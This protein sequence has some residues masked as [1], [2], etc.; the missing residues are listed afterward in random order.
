MSNS[1]PVEPCHAVGGTSVP[2]LVLA[3][4]PRE[5]ANA[6]ASPRVLLALL[7]VL[8][9]PMLALATAPQWWTDL[10]VLDSSA[11]TNDYAAINQGQLKNLA[12][13]AYYHL[14]TNVPPTVWSSQ[15]ATL[16]ALITGFQTS[17]NTARNDYAAV[18]IGQLKTVAKPFY[19]L[20]NKAGY[21]NSVHTSTNGYPWTGREVQANDY[22]MAN[23][24]QAKNLF[25]F[26]LAGFHRELPDSVKQQ[27][28]NADTHDL[29]TS[30]NQVLED[31]DFDG[32]GIS[33]IDEYIQISDP[34]VYTYPTEGAPI[35][36]IEGGDAQT[37]EINSF[38]P[39]PISVR[40]VGGNGQ[41][42]PS[43]PLQF[44]V[45]ASDGR[46]SRVNGIG[47]TTSTSLSIRTSIDGLASVWAMMPSTSGDMTI[48]ASA[49]G[50]SGA[51]VT[52]TLHANSGVVATPV[53]ASSTAYAT[54][55]RTV[56]ISCATSGAELRYTLDGSSPTQNN[57]LSS[58]IASGSAIT[59]PVPSTGHTLLRVKGY[60]SGYTPSQEKDAVYVIY[61]TDMKV[62]SGYAFS[63]AQMADGSL[64]TW[65][66]NSDGQLGLGNN[67]N[68]CVPEKNS[69]VTNA[70][71]I[72]VGPSFALALQNGTVWTWG[73]NSY[74]Q[75]GDGTY[76]SRS[77]PYPISSPTLS[78]VIQVAAGLNHSLAL[79]QDSTVWSWGANAYGQ[80]GDGTATTRLTPVQIIISGVIGST[81][82]SSI[83]AGNNFSMAL[84]SDSTVWAW[85]NNDNGRLGDKSGVNQYNAVQVKIA[86]GNLTGVIA[87]GARAS[88]AWAIKSDGTLWVWGSHLG[89]GTSSSSNYAIPSLTNVLLASSGPVSNNILVI[90]KDGSVLGWGDNT[91]LQ[92]DGT[93]T[94]YTS[95]TPIHA[96]VFTNAIAAST[97]G[98]HS[99]ILKSDG[100]LWAWGNKYCGQLGD[101]VARDYNAP[102]PIQVL[103]AKDHDGDGL[104]DAEELLMGSDPF[105]NDTNVDGILDSSSISLGIDPVC[106][107]VDGDGVDNANEL[108]RGT[109]PF[110]VQLPITSESS[111]VPVIELY[112]PNP[113]MWVNSDQ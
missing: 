49:I 72:A 31:D 71:A 13:K 67:A 36:Q 34:T 78:G 66:D 60:K 79:K 51:S 83:V 32:D 25:S 74:G 70:S 63:M 7:L 97:G 56:T 9:V 5:G 50:T 62:V 24:G 55:T 91:Q 18:N 84:L 58:T 29:I 64:W 87:I 6:Q 69:T 76:N 105:N 27:I 45:T 28:V 17:T 1:K 90:K 82:V 15:S 57:S 30:I 2:R 33:N 106:M 8:I 110:A 43:A 19:D 101:G 11:T 40:I 92:L 10:Q 85:G 65:G 108:L 12:T 44:S 77:T 14:Q 38:S 39:K 113:V 93:Q 22:A 89:N 80:L 100:S 20:L 23:I 37:A 35:L 59:I 95:S 75:L 47:A 112:R 68:L 54:S 109:N 53:L 88:S 99:L 94:S 96:D 103:L 81:T 86:S 98:Q 73:C 111:E 41:Y 4:H 107:D 16:S 104:S 3:K 102:N 42:L 26:D 48:T 61:H 52:F 46:L 21:T